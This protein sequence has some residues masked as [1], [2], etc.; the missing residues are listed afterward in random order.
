AVALGGPLDDLR[1]EDDEGRPV[2]D[3][4]GAVGQGLGA[5][6]VQPA[7]VRP[8]DDPLLV[9]PAVHLLR[10]GE[11][12]A[13]H[14]APRLLVGLVAAVA[15]L[16]AGAMP[17]GEGDRLVLEV[18]PGEFVREPLLVEAAPELERAGDPGVV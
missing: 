9:E 17:G 15:T 4:E 18:E 10:R 8:A 2:E 12:F 5:R 3:D 14:L 13:R 16:G 6:L 7:P 11:P 1:P